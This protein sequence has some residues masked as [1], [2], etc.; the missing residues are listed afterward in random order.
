MKVL[1]TGGAGFIGSALMR[2]LNSRGVEMVVIDKLD[3]KIH[4]GVEEIE[5]KRKSLKSQCKFFETNL[6]SKAV[7]TEAIQGCTHV[8]HLASETGTGQSMYEIASYCEVNLTETALLLETILE[9]A[10]NIEKFIVT[11]SRSVYGEGAFTCE[12]QTY[13]PTGRNLVDLKAGIFEIRHPTNGRFMTP[14]ATSVGASIQPKSVYGMTKFAQEQLINIF[15]E[16]N[17]IPSIA[18]RLQNV[19]GPGQSLRNPYTGILSIFST[20][21]LNNSVVEIFEDGL[22]TRDFVY[23][24]DVVTAIMNALEIE[25]N[26]NLILD[27]GSGKPTTV[28]QVVQKLSEFLGKDAEY[29]ISGAYRIGDIRHNFADINYANELLNFEPE[30]DFDSGLKNFAEWVLQQPKANDL[31]ERSIRELKSF[32]LYQG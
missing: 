24:D 3:P 23:V 28:L 5:Q 21:I 12:G 9:T 1:I 18:L 22:E 26:G 19:Y 32:G 16:A 8:V 6:K 10:D 25:T 29:R 2:R 11:S 31:Y 15:C 17:S 27:I 14:I 7:L 4:G 30:V 13:Y 20:R